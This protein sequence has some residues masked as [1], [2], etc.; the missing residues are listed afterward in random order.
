MSRTKDGREIL[1]DVALDAARKLVSTC[2][3]AGFTPPECQQP[4]LNRA[5]I[6]LGHVS[7]ALRMSRHELDPDVVRGLT[8]TT[9]AA[10]AWLDATNARLSS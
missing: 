2:D 4:L 6:L 8:A 10:Q 3:S 1:W 5:A 7:D 9:P